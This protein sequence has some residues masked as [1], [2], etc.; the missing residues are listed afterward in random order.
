MLPRDTWRDER[1]SQSIA[2][3]ARQALVDGSRY[4]SSST[5][6]SL[7]RATGSNSPFV[8]QLL[9]N[10]LTAVICTHHLPIS[11]QTTWP[12]KG[13][14]GN[15][16]TRHR[17]TVCSWIRRGYQR[18]VRLVSVCLW[19]T[20]RQAS[21]K[22]TAGQ[23]NIGQLVWGLLANCSSALYKAWTNW[24]FAWRLSAFPGQLSVAYIYCSCD[25]GGGDS[26]DHLFPSHFFPISLYIHFPLHVF[27]VHL[28]PLFE[29]CT[30]RLDY[31]FLEANASEKYVIYNKIQYCIAK[32]LDDFSYENQLIDD[33]SSDSF[34][35][36]NCQLSW[37]NYCK[38]SKV[39]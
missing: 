17:A 39:L 4:G 29:L 26:H 34:L 21:L 2:F 11:S 5:P 7:T 20:D 9:D 31:W 22:V 24:D 10:R 14:A 32:P 3:C 8:G 16:N 23:K 25:L 33:G 1:K 36:L 6:P 27:S 28:L 30:M 15:I 19:D 13:S 38:C 18:N 37:R 35:K 12:A